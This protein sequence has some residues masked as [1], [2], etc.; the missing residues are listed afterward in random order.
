MGCVT[1]GPEKRTGRARV[2]VV[3]FG[4]EA[5]RCN[6]QPWHTVDAL[7][8]RLARTGH[9][10]TLVTDAG[11]PPLDRPYPIL[12]MPRL[13]RGGRPSPDL[14]VI[15]E[16]ER[17]RHLYLV[18]GITGLLRLRPLPGR[19]EVHYII[20][21]PRLKVAE[22]LSV[23]PIH[24][25][26][27]RRLLWRPLCNALI[28]V[29]L[30]RRAW[31]RSGIHRPVYVTPTTRHRL[32]SAGLPEGP[33]L[34]PEP[35]LSNIPPKPS[36]GPPV[37]GYFGPPLACRG[38]WRAI[39][40]FESCCDRGLDL[41]LLMLIRPDEPEALGRLKR[42]IARSRWRDR[43]QLVARHLDLPS[44]CHR[45]GRCHAFLLPF[46]APVSE[47]PLALLEAAAS[48]RPTFAFDRPGIGDL[49][50]RLGA[51]IADHPCEL[52]EQLAF[53]AQQ[54]LCATA[55]P[56]WA[57]TG[58]E[59]PGEEAQHG[60]ADLRMIA[61]IGPDGVGKTT[62]LRLLHEWLRCRG[63]EPLRVWSR[64]RNYLSLPFVALMH[65]SGHCRR[66]RF[67]EGRI[68]IRDF[69]GS[70]GLGRMFLALQSLDQRLDL[71]IRFRSRRLILC[72]RCLYD[73]LV[74]LALDTGLERMVMEGLAPSLLRRLPSPHRV[75][76]LDRPPGEIAADRPDALADGRFEL[77]R[78]LYLELAR[79][80]DIPVIRVGGAAAETAAAILAALAPGP[81]R[82]RESA[83]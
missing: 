3:C 6:R 46:L 41:R 72:D 49:G 75:F 25:L 60:L 35:R 32:V 51:R 37:I 57:R 24:L 66:I 17:P 26:H 34:P 31:K 77:R 67:R 9:A 43:I 62:V 5:D 58:S 15:L 30:L 68:G 40:T 2:L 59:E 45:L 11:A 44:L 20:A 21:S 83:A 71:L 81:A 38:A 42:R 18:G 28:P 74:D 63:I 1:H 50:R 7:C 22:V 54:G 39:E 53:A 36:V 12:R 73:T 70:P 14:R 4:F 13:F 55:P 52:V 48:G 27:E 47:A 16:S 64:Y 76:L 19:A 80:L 29:F 8:G 78:K 23:G 61:L 82:L 79:R 33:L 10:V 69:R 65:L 56:S